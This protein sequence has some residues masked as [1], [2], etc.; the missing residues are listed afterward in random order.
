MLSYDNGVNQERR[1]RAVRFLRA[2]ES[3]VGA[4]A[5]ALTIP[6][7]VCLWFHFPVEWRQQA[8]HSFGKW[9]MYLALALTFACLM[10]WLTKRRTR[11]VLRRETKGHE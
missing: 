7:F 8:L 5:L 9:M 4:V 3:V 11:S 2:H 1:K 10:H 6:A